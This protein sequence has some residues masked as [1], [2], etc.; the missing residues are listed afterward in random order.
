MRFNNC[1]AYMYV[2]DD[3]IRRMMR[4]LKRKYPCKG[5]AIKLAISCASIVAKM[6]VHIKGYPDW[7]AMA[8]NS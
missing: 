3:K 1:D 4:F 8:H 7:L 2:R 6:V 5:K